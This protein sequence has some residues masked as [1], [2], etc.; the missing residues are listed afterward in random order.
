MILEE[1]QQPRLA[2]LQFLRDTE[3]S[4]PHAQLFAMILSLYRAGLKH[5]VEPHHAY[6]SELLQCV[7]HLCVETHALIS[8]LARDA[9][10][11]ALKR[12]LRA[13]EFLQFEE[14]YVYVSM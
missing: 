9:L 11:R 8:Y 4:V 2:S 12:S 3:T 6:A 5:L 13:K 14:E 1:L 10:S 7:K